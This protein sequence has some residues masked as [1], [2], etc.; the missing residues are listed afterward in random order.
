MST[1]PVYDPSANRPYVAFYKGK[2]LEVKATSSFEAQQLA[3]KQ[4]RAK[5]AYDVTVVLADVEISTSS[6]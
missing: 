4:F 6:I 5:K 1:V 2:K 3:A